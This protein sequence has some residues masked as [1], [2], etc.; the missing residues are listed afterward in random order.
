VTWTL[1]SFG[2]ARVCSVPA[3]ASRATAA[4]S[5]L[6]VIPL[7]LTLA[8]A[9]GSAHRIE[10]EASD[11]WHAFTH[12]AE[13]DASGATASAASHSRLL[14]G[15]GNRYD[16]WRIAVRVWR[17]H[18]LL[19]VGAGNYP[20]S[21]YE[22]R[23]TI[24]DIDQPHSVELQTLSELGL[25]GLL[26]LAAFVAAVA[27]G[28]VR[29][30][31]DAARSWCSQALTVG[32]LGVFVAWLTQ[33]S[34][35][36]M[37]LLPGLT[38]IALAASAV[39]VRSSDQSRRVEPAASAARDRS[40]LAGRRAI[41]LGAAAVIA[42]LIVAGASLTRQGLAEI[43]RSR[44]QGELETSPATTLTNIKRS[45]AIDPDS[46]Q[47]YYIK[48]AALA[49]FDDAPGAEAALRAALAREPDNFVTWTL[50]GD[51]ASREGSSSVAAQDYMRAL[52]LNPRDPTLIALVHPRTTTH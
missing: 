45:L 26:L 16:Y 13:P 10:R 14:S 31:R 6:L 30:R 29:M 47:S 34:A 7:V 39:L 20:R 12:L 23:A 50:L 49:R 51:V 42:T 22:Q 52:R 38:A 46:V 9:V 27:W 32:S 41:A 25:P 21:Y 5:W 1:L 48:S 36:W 37:Q 18:P 8:V 4:A 11:Q 44:A 35:D 43:Y 17:D 24:E 33:A 15:G 2:W 28:V 19:G 40:V 3:L